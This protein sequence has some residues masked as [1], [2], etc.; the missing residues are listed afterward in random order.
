MWPQNWIEWRV[1]KTDRRLKA[2]EIVYSMYV[3]FSWIKEKAEAVASAL[4]T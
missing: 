2:S 3:L 1:N 4:S